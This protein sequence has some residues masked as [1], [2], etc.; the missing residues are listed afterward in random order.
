MRR[1]QHAQRRVD[2]TDIGYRAVV[3]PLREPKPAVFARD[4]DAERT[5]GT[6]TLENI[7]GNVARPL[8][9]VPVNI[10]RKER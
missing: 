9:L 7:R 4:L 1:E 5:D 2:A 10:G 8:D 3:A 6:E